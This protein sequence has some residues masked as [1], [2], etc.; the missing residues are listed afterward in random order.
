M[1]RHR[2]KL[3]GFRTSV[4]NQVHA[5]AMGQGLCR[6]KKLWAGVGRKKLESLVLDPRKNGWSASPEYARHRA[7]PSSASAPWRHGS[8]GQPPSLL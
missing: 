7:S 5:L 6:S 4:K 8:L 3:V 1:L 2:H